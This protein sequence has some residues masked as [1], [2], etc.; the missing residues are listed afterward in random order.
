MT[1]TLPAAAPAP[2]SRRPRLDRAGAL[3]PTLVAGALAVVAIA[4]RWRGGDY[5]AHFFRVALVERDGFEVW[6]NQ[7]FG[8]H[9]TLGYGALFPVLGA[10]IGIWPI[11]VLSAAAAAL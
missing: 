9:H 10:A 3:V 4:L 8:G 7:W 11:A 5:P 1:A 2:T 6:N